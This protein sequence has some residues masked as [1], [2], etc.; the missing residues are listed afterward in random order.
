MGTRSAGDIVYRPVSRRKGSVIT[1]SRMW[2]GPDHLLMVKEIGFSE[3]YKRFYFE[4]I[5]AFIIKK[6]ARY[7]ILAAIIPFIWASSFALALEASP[8]VKSILSLFFF[9]IWAVHLLKGPSCKAWMVTGIN[10]EPLPMFR[11]ARAA[12]K[13]WQLIEP[14][15]IDAQGRFSLEEMEAEGMR[16][17]Q[18]SAPPPPPQ[19]PEPAEDEPQKD[20]F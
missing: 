11:R 19:A 20:L 1:Y 4:D 16:R 8:V 9:L 5:Q 12:R 17:K 15:L 3:E 6:D 7:P 18:A 13:F 14:D 10:R 2:K